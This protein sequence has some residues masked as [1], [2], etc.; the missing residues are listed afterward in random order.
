MLLRYH[1]PGRAFDI[2]E[3]TVTAVAEVAFAVAIVWCGPG[4]SSDPID[5]DA[6]RFRL[7]VGLRKVGGDWLLAHE[8]HAVPAT[9]Q[10]RV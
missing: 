6:F 8:H 10:A 9:G 2:R 3:L 7:T 4:S 1:R 5:K